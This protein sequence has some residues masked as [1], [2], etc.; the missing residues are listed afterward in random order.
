MKRKELENFKT[1]PLPEVDKEVRLHEE[2]LMN[3]K[4]DL[5]LGKVKNIREIRQIKK[6]LAQLLTI[7]RSR[8]NT[9]K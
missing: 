6:S 7:K 4:K 2:R 1:K 8:A 9:D 5:V 3:L